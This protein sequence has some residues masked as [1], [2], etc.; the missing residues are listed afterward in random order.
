MSKS[1]DAV[2]RIIEEDPGAAF[3]NDTAKYVVS[4]TL[5]SADAWQNSQLLGGYSA[6]V[7]RDL[8]ERVDGGIYM[9][10]S[11][12]LVRALLSERL[13]DELHLFVY[14]VV[15]GNGAKL[16]PDGSHRTALA[17]GYDNGVVHLTYA[18]VREA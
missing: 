6:S 8:K 14:P 11:G 5:R 4:A 10:G 16:F 12:Q 1:L 3:F 13:V 15:L 9:S 17:L 2:R 18:P 7:V